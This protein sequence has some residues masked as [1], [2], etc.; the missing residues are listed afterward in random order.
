MK[1]Q[2]VRNPFKTSYRT[3]I[4]IKKLFVVSCNLFF[5]FHW[6]IKVSGILHVLCGS[7]LYS[8]FLFELSLLKLTFL[9]M[10]SGLIECCR[11]S[12][13]STEKGIHQMFIINTQLLIKMKRVLFL[14]YILHC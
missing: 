12:H 3:S 4:W 1:L 5:F 6:T 8:S 7:H 13:F 2:A 11:F 14:R 9:Y 10:N